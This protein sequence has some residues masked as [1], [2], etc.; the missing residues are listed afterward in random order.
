MTVTARDLG[1]DG[2]PDWTLDAVC[3]G[4][5]VEMFFPNGKGHS[6]REGKA[7][8]A[9]CPVTVPCLED[10]LSAERQEPYTFGVRGGLAAHERR[11]I[12]QRE[13]KAA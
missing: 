5:P 10:A 12:V 3:V 11:T 6:A 13:R 8:C 2:T 1:M 9:R 4:F 7:V